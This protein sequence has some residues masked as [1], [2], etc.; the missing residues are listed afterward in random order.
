MYAQNRPVTRAPRD[1]VSSWTTQLYRAT[2]I[3]SID[4]EISEVRVTTEPDVLRAFLFSPLQC[5]AQSHMGTYT[6]TTT[7]KF[8]SIFSLTS[9]NLP[10]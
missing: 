8:S 9:L 6:P 5:V 4:E 10:S 3:Y 2:R 7:Q 1:R